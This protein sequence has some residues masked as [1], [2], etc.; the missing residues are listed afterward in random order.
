MGKMNLKINTIMNGWSA[1][2][3][4]NSEG[5]FNSS[6]AIDPD[7]P[8]TASAIR[9]SGFAVPV[10]YAKFSGA[11]V[12]TAVIAQIT[13]PKDN[14]TYVV[15]VGG[16][17]ISYNNTLG[18]ETLVGT[19]A[20][21]NAQG[22]AYYNNYIYIF[23]TGASKDDVSRYGPLNNSPTLVDNVWKGV[24]L[25]SLTALTNTAYA[26][27]RGVTIPNHWAHV[28]P[29]DNA[30]YFCDFK[31]GQGFLN[32]IKTSKT[33]NEGDTNNGSAYQV[34][35]L[36]FGFYPTDIESYNITDVVVVGFQTTDTTVDQGNAFAIF[37]D[38]TNTTAFYRN[39]PIPDPMATAI[40]NTNGILLIWSGNAING[41]R[42]SKY[43][44]GDQLHEVVYQEEGTPPF[45]GAV[46][47]KG[48]R[49]LW[50]GWMTYP[51]AS[52]VVF[53]INSKNLRLGSSLASPYS[54]PQAIQ[55]IATPSTTGATQIITALKFVQQS[56]NIQPKIIIAW[57]DASVAYGIDQYSATATLS[58]VMRWMFNVGKKFK[59]TRI[60]IPLAGV[61]NASTTI[62][63]L[64]YIDDLST[65]FSSL[66]VIN[67]TNYPSARKVIYRTPQL[68]NATGQ[69]NFIFE[70]TWTNTNPLPAAFPIMIDLEIFDDEPDSF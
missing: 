1:A 42:L 13:N 15:T 61:V 63:P 41:I 60:R 21:S 55:C 46:A 3:Y 67:N 28:H 56:S 19:V 11:N 54:N 12:D 52:S 27:F 47:I 40:V 57:R 4:F 35:S 34:L 43:V 18:S 8:I 70:L 22:A 20:G 17:L 9:T 48:N 10:G 36:P 51:I 68:T 33:T 50:G 53:A 37:W 65:T 24:T 62:T 26:A 38:T 25:G 32:K 7:F 30:L 44:G 59:I 14:N 29:G 5:T 58:S 69:N 23:G 45:Q 49:V 6:V 16:K 39:I 66:N 31:N 2:Q 64:I